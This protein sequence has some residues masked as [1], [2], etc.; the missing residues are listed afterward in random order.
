MISMYDKWV[1]AVDEG[2]LCGVVCIDQSAAFDVIDHKLLLD[3]LKLYGFEEDALLWMQN[4]LIA[5]CDDK[6]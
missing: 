2:K 5:V 1:R 6:R 4:Y 3:K